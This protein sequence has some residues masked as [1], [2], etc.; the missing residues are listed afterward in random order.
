DGIRGSTFHNDGSWQGFEG[1]DL[2]AIVD[3]GEAKLL[4]RITCGFLEN[5]YVWIFLPQ[6]VEI[7]IS[8][9]GKT[10]DLIQHTRD[11]ALVRNSQPQFKDYVA[12][13]PDMRARYVRIKARNVGICPD[14]HPGAGGKAWLFCDEIIIE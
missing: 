4:K 6:V 11:K 12:D 7:S 1:D 13:L 2:E 9:D 10:F 14:W 3:L 5:Q 8:R